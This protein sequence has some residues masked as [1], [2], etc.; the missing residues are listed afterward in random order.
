MTCAPS[1]RSTHVKSR[2][3]RRCAVMARPAMRPERRLGPNIVPSSAARPLMCPPAMPATSPA[4]N[5]PAIGPPVTPCTRQDRSVRTPPRHLRAIGKHWS[6][7]Y[8]GRSIGRSPASRARARRRAAG[9]GRRPRCSPD[10]RREP[11]T[12]IPA[13]CPR[14][15]QVAPRWRTASAR[16][17]PRPLRDRAPRRCRSPGAS[18]SGARLVGVEDRP[19]GRRALREQ[20]RRPGRA[21]AGVSSWKRTPSAFTQISLRTPRAAMPRSPAGSRSSGVP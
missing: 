2:S 15:C 20:R 1:P 13:T 9:R 19:A 8:G 5:S 16:G 12:G 6:A 4:A 17:R 21:A 7:A 14:S 3:P 11:A 10:G 18:A